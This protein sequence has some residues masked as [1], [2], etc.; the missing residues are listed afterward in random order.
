M[1][2]V[3]VVLS[4]GY[5]DGN[6]ARGIG[7][8][9]AYGSDGVYVVGCIQRDIVRFAAHN[10]ILEPYIELGIFGW[11]PVM[12]GLFGGLLGFWRCAKWSKGTETWWLWQGWA[13]GATAFLFSAM[14]HGSG[15]RGNTL[16]AILGIGFAGLAMFKKDA[17][18]HYKI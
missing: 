18:Y 3:G 7:L 4:R 6:L 16:W 14:L 11:I 1:I 10:G 8:D 2:T 9:A 12:L 15:W 17:Y 13:A 5:A